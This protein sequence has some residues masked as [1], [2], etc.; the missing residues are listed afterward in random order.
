MI[1]QYDNAECTLATCVLYI[2]T[3][4]GCDHQEA[5]DRTEIRL[6]KRRHAILESRFVFEPVVEGSPVCGVV[7]R[8]AK[9]M[10]ADLTVL[11]ASNVVELL[12]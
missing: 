6:K 5:L 2:V 4:H 10:A 11:A 7:S 3:K 12:V 8:V 9:I 1:S